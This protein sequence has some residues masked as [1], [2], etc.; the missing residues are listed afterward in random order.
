M[1]TH[2]LI[3]APPTAFHADGRIDLEVVTPLANHL[4]QQGVIGV[5]VN[6]TTGEGMSLTTEE[7]IQ[8]AAAWRR[9]LPDGM[10]LFVHVGHNS[11]GDAR[12]LAQ[13]AEDIGAD[14]VA[15]IAP[16]FFRP[17]DLHGVV[18]WC[19][20]VAEAA[21]QLP[22]YYYHIPSMSG[23]SVSIARFLERAGDGIPNLRGVKFTFEA[24][25]DYHEAMLLGGGRYDVLWGRDEMLLGALAM[26]ATGA[27]GSTYN[28]IAPV[29]LRMIEAF[30]RHDWPTARELQAQSI[31]FINRLQATGNFFSALKAVLSMQGIPITPAVRPPLSA[32]AEERLV[33]LTLPEACQL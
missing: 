26:G 33:S 25:G 14:A 31:A 6:G 23:V 21:P 9:V 8:L 1:K 32:V 16:N 5:F 4:R 15:A 22:F 12:R 27:V 20:R 2:G 19:A 30:T 29:Y 17:S 28:A 11:L 13:H 3:A 10:K 24:L 7:R 18:D